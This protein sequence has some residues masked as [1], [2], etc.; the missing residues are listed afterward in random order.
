MKKER[1]KKSLLNSGERMCLWRKRRRKKSRKKRRKK[2]KRKSH[3]SQERMKTSPSENGWAG[4]IDHAPDFLLLPR[5][6]F[7][8]VGA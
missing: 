2:A 4:L 6:D 7:I 5:L 1:S 3:P 8:V